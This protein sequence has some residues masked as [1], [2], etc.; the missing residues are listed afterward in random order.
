MVGFKQEEILMSQR[1]INLA[2]DAF[3]LEAI[4]DYNAIPD[5]AVIES[6]VEQDYI[7]LEDL[8]DQLDEEGRLGA[9]MPDEEDD[10]S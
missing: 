6:L 3:E 5:I 7:S 2:L 1:I 4:L 8:E 10:D 9:D